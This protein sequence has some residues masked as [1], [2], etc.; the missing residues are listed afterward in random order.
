MSDILNK[1][2]IQ[3]EKEVEESKQKNPLSE[4]QKRVKANERNFKASL[5]KS[6]L[7][8][9]AEI[10]K[11]S[12]SLGII[13]RDFDHRKIALI[14]NRYADAI[15]VLT[16]ET[17]FQ[18][19]LKYLKDVSE[20]SSLPILRKDFII[21]EY[22]IVEARD[23]GA[24]AILLIATILDR[25]SLKQFIER[26]KSLNMDS[27][28]EVHNER[29]LEKV[30]SIDAEIVGI[31]NRDLN[32]FYMSLDTTKKLAKNIPKGKI[33]VS[34]SGME[35]AENIN[36]MRGIVDA[37]LIGTSFMKANDIEEKIKTMIY[38]S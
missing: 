4:L 30:L 17:F 1:I 21:D 27:L 2:V 25:S 18:G 13:R 38:S 11:A 31:N 28:C 9:I 20:I 37:V 35:S 29:E 14:Y 32:T 15:S 24:S 26:A 12:P 8:L 7:A 23:A 19:S 22:Q 3:K 33:I 34:E 10:K 5:R 36:E 16:D 6:S